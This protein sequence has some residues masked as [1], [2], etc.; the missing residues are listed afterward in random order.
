M[1]TEIRL[2]Q[3]SH[4]A[5]CGCKIS[6]KVLETILH[7]EQLHSEQAKFFDPN[8][9]VGNETRDD[10]AVYDIGNGTGIIS[11][12]DFFMPIVDDPFDFGRIAATNAISDI[13]AMGGK[14]IMAIAILG[15]PINTLAPEIARQ[16]IEGGRAVCQAAGISLAGGHSIDA[17]EPIF[18]LAVTGIINI[19]RVKRNNQAKAGS[20]LFLTKPLG[21]GVLTTAEKKGVLQP[22]HQGIAKDIMCQL[23]KAGADFAE[24]EGVTAM[25]DV[26][27]F[28]LLGHLSEIC[29]GSGVQAKVKFSQVPR[30]PDVDVYIE[31]GCVPGGTGRNFDSYGHLMGEMTLPQR[32]L[33][34]D[35]QTSGG[36]LLAIL[37]DAVEKAKAV[38]RSHNIDFVAI[39]ELT[40]PY[41]GRALI[42]VF[43]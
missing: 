36:L 18:G 29:E 43:E 30:L 9:L 38:A 31:K 41:S 28:G 35:P 8:L 3:Y 14:P 13:Y 39:G 25:T 24:I 15:W 7:S 4:G 34:C 1:S 5:G 10:A 19:E 33:L 26:T 32:H 16:V 42:E 21:V 22:E 27:G 20:L 6:P 23:N 40:E 12:T 17:P 37:P 2:T 11:T